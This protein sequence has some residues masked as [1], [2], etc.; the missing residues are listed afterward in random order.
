MNSLLEKIS[1]FFAVVAIISLVV[2]ACLVV[3]PTQALDSP[4]RWPVAILLISCSIS[5]VFGLIA[6]SEHRTRIKHLQEWAN[7]LSFREAPWEKLSKEAKMSAMLKVVQS[8]AESSSRSP[9]S[10]PGSAESVEGK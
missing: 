6:F 9:F 3:F 1:L 5:I 7:M 10:P 8:M 2:T 4:W